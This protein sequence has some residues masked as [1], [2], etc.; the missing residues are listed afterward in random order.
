MTASLCWRLAVA[1][2]LGA[3]VAS[4]VTATSS[5]VEAGSN[6]ILPPTPDSLKGDLS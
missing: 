1:V 6:R 5:L 4:S 2:A 3:A